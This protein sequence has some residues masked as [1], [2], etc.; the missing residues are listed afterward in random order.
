MLNSRNKSFRY[1]NNRCALF[2]ES[3]K[4]LLSLIISDIL[5]TKI[6]FLIRSFMY[7]SK[8]IEKNI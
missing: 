7:V 1:N 5:K 2:K 8:N 3:N 6:Y 4:G